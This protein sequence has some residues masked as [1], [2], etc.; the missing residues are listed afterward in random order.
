[1]GCYRDSFIFCLY[2]WFVVEDKWTSRG[3]FSWVTMHCLCYSSSSTV[4]AA[5]DDLLMLTLCLCVSDKVHSE[6]WF[7]STFIVLNRGG[8]IYVCASAHT[9]HT[10]LVNVVNEVFEDRLITPD[11]G[12]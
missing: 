5:A 10:L 6:V 9:T 1:V 12:L 2:N 7:I 8:D 11:C 4:T 3:T